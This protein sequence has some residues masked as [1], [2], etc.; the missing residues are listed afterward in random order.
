MDQ[1]T[2][3]QARAVKLAALGPFLL[4]WLLLPAQR[5]LLGRI[6]LQLALQRVANGATFGTG[7]PIVVVGAI[8]VNCV[9]KG[10]MVTQLAL[11]VLLAYSAGVHIVLMR[12]PHAQRVLLARIRLTQGLFRALHAQEAHTP[13]V[14]AS[15]RV[16]RVVLMARTVVA[17]SLLAISVPLA[18]IPLE[19]GI[20]NVPNVLLGRTSQAQGARGAT[21]A[22][23]P[24]TL[25]A[26][27]SPNACPAAVARTLLPRVFQAASTALLVPTS[28]APPP[29]RA[30]SARVPAIGEV[31]VALHAL[32]VAEARFP[33]LQVQQPVCHVVQA[34]MAPVKDRPRVHSVLQETMHPARAWLCARD[35]QSACTLPPWQPAFV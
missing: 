12:C 2:S 33:P 13:L 3:I 30:C 20:Q 8:G 31:Q 10:T 16:P 32:L 15:R 1:A 21:Y 17:V 9:C 14:W 35:V 25:P 5:A 18:L 27:V 4:P 22:P 7:G 23:V 24:V 11:C 6:H 28:W 19:A 34:V 26:L 29:P